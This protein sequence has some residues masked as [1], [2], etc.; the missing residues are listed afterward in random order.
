MDDS[1]LVTSDNTGGTGSIT[2]IPTG[3]IIPTP[4]IVTPVYTPATY[5]TVPTP[6]NPA[7]TTTWT[8]INIRPK[9]TTFDLPVNE[10]PVAVYV[11]GRMMTLGILGSDVQAAYTGDQLIFAPEVFSL[12]SD[13]STTL[14][15]E[16]PDVFYHYNVI[17][18]FEDSTKIDVLLLSEIAKH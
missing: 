14:I 7:P 11:N 12:T 9:Y 5:P 18:Y 2:I 8:Y 1:V 6:Y 10:C 4:T 15:I 13:S 17:G 3:T 16:Y